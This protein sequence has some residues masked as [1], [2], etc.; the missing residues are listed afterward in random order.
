LAETN[1]P[2]RCDLKVHRHVAE[3]TVVVGVSLFLS[4]ERPEGILELSMDVF[5]KLQ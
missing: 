3:K 1:V 5:E 4:G 2:V